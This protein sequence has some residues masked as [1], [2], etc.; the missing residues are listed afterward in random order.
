MHLTWFESQDD[1]GNFVAKGIGSGNSGFIIRA[2]SETVSGNNLGLAEGNGVKLISTGTVQ[3]LP[4]GCASFDIPEG[5]A[6]MM[7]TIQI[8]QGMA[9]DV[10]QTEYRTAACPAGQEGHIVQSLNVVHHPDGS[11]SA[12]SIVLTSGESFDRPA[13]H[14][15]WQEHA[16]NCKDPVTLASLDSNTQQVTGVD[17]SALLSSGVAGTV[18]AVVNNSLGTVDCRDAEQQDERERSQNEEEEENEN[19]FSTCAGEVDVAAL[20]SIGE[21]EVTI[22]RTENVTQPCGGTSGSFSD[23]VSGHAGIVQHT[24]WNGEAHY[25]RHIMRHNMDD[26][27]NINQTEN[28]RRNFRERWTGVSISCDRQERLNI[29]CNS[30]YPQFTGSR[31][32]SL[33]S[34]GFNY[35]RT[36]LIRGWANEVSLTPNDPQNPA[37]NY[38]GGQSGCGWREHERWSCSGGTQVSQGHRTRDF[39]VSQ[40][41]Q[42]PSIPGWSLQSPA[43]CQ[44]TRTSGGCVVVTERRTFTSNAPGQGSWSG[45]SVISSVDN[46]PSPSGGSGGG[47]NGGGGGGGNCLMA[48]TMIAMADGSRKAIELLEA[49][50]MTVA[51]RVVKTLKRGWDDK[52]LTNIH[53]MFMTNGGLF[54]YDGVVGT[55]RHPLFTQETGWVEMGDFKKAT[56]VKNPDVR[57]VYNLLMENNV[58]P[59]SG[60]SGE[61]YYYADDLN[62]LHNSAEKGRLKLSASMND[63]TSYV[64]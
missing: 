64:A 15:L 5:S 32:Q 26:A 60:D 24:A 53:E 13:Y 61:I 25:Q 39:R 62:N 11:T 49:G 58:I 41:A 31:Y 23:A 57:Q 36:N 18:G 46:C 16:N 33:D 3:S 14:F 54:E 9:E 38:R 40:L 34:R 7:F 47:G 28:S 55:G 4:A 51:G 6:V 43:Q 21:V 30:V 2:L 48:G 1:N 56:P 45:W 44:Q 10:V 22:E 37:W 63:V 59:V 27:L 29:T 50:D 17:L 8:P 52:N 20:Q 12:G 42:N 19:A 35:T